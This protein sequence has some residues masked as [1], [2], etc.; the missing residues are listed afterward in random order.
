MAQKVVARVVAGVIGRLVVAGGRDGAE[1][2]PTRRTSRTR[3]DRCR[4][5]GVCMA[6]GLSTLGA[7]RVAVLRHGAAAGTWALPHGGAAAM[8]AGTLAAVSRH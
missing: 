4:L 5:G 8:P 2:D 3:D 1:S 6:Q 7:A